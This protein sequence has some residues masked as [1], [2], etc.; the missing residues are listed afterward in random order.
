MVNFSADIDLYNI[1]ERVSNKC[2]D[3]AQH[4]YT[5][6]GG[7]QKMNKINGDI[8]ITTDTIFFFDMDGTLIDTNLANFLSYKKAIHSVKKS[9]PDLTYNPDNRLNRSNLKNAVPDLSE[10]DY[11]R[12]IQEKEEYYKDFLK[13]TKVNTE[14][15]DILSKYSKTNKTV[16]VTNC[17]KDRALTI[18]NH[19]GLAD[20]FDN[21]FY[22]HTT[23][24]GEKINKFQNA[25]SKLRVPANLVVAFEN[26]EIEIA[27]AKQAGIKI[28]NPEII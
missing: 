12:I 3:Q 1:N 7:K 28:I 16:L 22:R 11:E 25:I 5:N 2:K 4:S 21:I 26:E 23:D 18:L 9:D 8:N 10:T 6:Q 15:V 17:R 20:K 19:F 27:D 14:M 24:N 13:E